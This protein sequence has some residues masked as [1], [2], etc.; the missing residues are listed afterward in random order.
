MRIPQLTSTWSRRI[1]VTATLGLLVTAIAGSGAAGLG[2]MATGGGGSLS[3]PK[4]LGVKASLRP[5]ANPT[6]QDLPNP[7]SSTRRNTKRGISTSIATGQRYLCGTDRDD[8][9]SVPRLGNFVE[10]W[11][12][13][14]STFG[15]N[16]TIRAQN[17]RP[18]E[19]DGGAGNDSG[20]FDSCD[21]LHNIEQPTISGD[22]PGVLPSQLKQ[23][24]DVNDR[25][26]PARI[27]CTTGTDGQRL[28]RIVEEPALRAVDATP[29][30]EWQ[31]VAF[32]P[33][34]FRWDG[35][36]WKLQA[37]SRWVW[38]RTYDKQVT[39]FPNNAWRRLDTNQRWFQW[40]A[41]PQSG[42]YRVLLTLHWYADEGVPASDFTTWAGPHYGPFED[43]THQWCEYPS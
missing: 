32:M 26:S 20:Q 16:D 9:I 21:R 14:V 37:T 22:C 3:A 1:A 31:F 4:T 13:S 6:V 34:L 27:E 24:S 7:C 30:V 12:T 43:S 42:I 19:I 38:D 28:M 33:S 35:S 5:A 15:G 41:P 39:A 29:A 2:T 36:Q 17:G 25:F 8:R 23:P 18:D 11:G 40:Y 10:T